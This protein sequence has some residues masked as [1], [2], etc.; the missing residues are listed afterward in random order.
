MGTTP[1]YVEVKSNAN[2]E[3]RVQKKGYLES[4]LLITTLSP[5]LIHLSLSP[6]NQF[7]QIQLSGMQK[8]NGSR[9][10]NRILS[11][12]FLGATILS[13]VASLHFKQEAD[14]YYN[15][16]LHAGNPDQ[17]NAYYD[18]SRCNDRYATI[19]FGCFQLNFILWTYFFLKSR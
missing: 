13:G 8:K 2:A 15:K 10:R 3:I 6:I 5:K 14:D 17:M 12:G 7:Q 18:D 4:R 1:T 11:W 19:A 9:V 16:Y